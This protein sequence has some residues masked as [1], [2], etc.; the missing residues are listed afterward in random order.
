M[1]YLS[2]V[3]VSDEIFELLIEMTKIVFYFGSMLISDW[4]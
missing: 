2:G 3:L 4:N 1:N